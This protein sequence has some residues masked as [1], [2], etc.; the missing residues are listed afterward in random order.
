MDNLNGNSK[1]CVN[2]KVYVRELTEEKETTVGEA[3][4]MT[5]PD[6]ERQSQLSRR[7]RWRE[8]KGT[9]AEA[10]RGRDR[11]DERRKQLVTKGE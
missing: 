3:D 5:R 6:E 11:K 9:K 2:K 8:T 4:K 7:G 1:L 10:E